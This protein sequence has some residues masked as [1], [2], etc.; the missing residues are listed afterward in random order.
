MHDNGTKKLCDT[1]DVTVDFIVILAFI[2]ILV[3]VDLIVIL[4]MVE[5]IL[6]TE[7]WHLPL[8]HRIMCMRV[9]EPDS[10]L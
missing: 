10:N 5:L 4:V 7:G 8:P 1:D 6:P 2:V 3:T 9:W